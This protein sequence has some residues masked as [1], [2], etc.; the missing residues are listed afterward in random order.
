MRRTTNNNSKDI[1]LKIDDMVKCT[2]YVD[3]CLKFVGHEDEAIPL[4]SDLREMLARDRFLLTMWVSN[5]PKIITCVPQFERAG[6]VKDLY[7]N[8]KS[9]AQVKIK[10]SV[11]SATTTKRLK[12]R[13]A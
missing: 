1:G 4:V 8:P 10:C 9:I 12:N 3:D 5:S 2:F 7:L 13:Y 6:T 11:A